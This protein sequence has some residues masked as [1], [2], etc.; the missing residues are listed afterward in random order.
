[1][2]SLTDMWEEND[3]LAFERCYEYDEAEYYQNNDIE[4]QVGMESN[5][6]PQW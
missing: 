3:D 5:Q 4:E 2:M 6:N 1:M